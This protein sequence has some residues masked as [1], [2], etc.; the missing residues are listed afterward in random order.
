MEK[1]ER[2][3]K[4]PV[5]FL[6]AIFS[7]S[8]HAEKLSGIT[9][10]AYILQADSFEQN[11]EEAVRKL[12]DSERKLLIMDYSFSGSDRDRW[13]RDELDRIREGMEGRKII[14]YISIGEAED[15]RYY[16]DE[17]AS[18]LELENPDWEGNY[19]VFYW[20]SAW[21]NTVLDYVK[22]IID[23]GFDGIYLDIIDAYQYF[24]Y[25]RKTG[26]W[27]K[28]RINPETGN[29]F[30]KDM[31]D[32]VSVISDFCRGK[33]ENFAIVPQNGSE[34]LDYPEYVS[35][36]DG[37]G[38]EDLYTDSNR[39]Q[40]SEHT[41]EV[42]GNLENLKGTGKPVFLTEYA[43]RKKY[44]EYAVNLNSENRYILLFTDRGLDKMGR[45]ISP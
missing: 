43:T 27:L 41:E 22:I 4:I 16:W 35:V 24:E 38:I 10:F 6:L 31:I 40:D 21:Q 19:K 26:E 11:R 13:K 18:F 7:A 32:W 2:I 28:N 20:N 44:T 5:I 30:R 25:D 12:H 39:R 3:S 29:S 8:V 14:S 17:K 1:G 9:S 36:I 37:I 42:L 15:Y 34:L 45:C 33:S 23:Q